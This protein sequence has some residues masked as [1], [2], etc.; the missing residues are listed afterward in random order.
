MIAAGGIL[1]LNI[2]L[3]YPDEPGLY[4]VDKE[5]VDFAK[6]QRKIAV[7]LLQLRTIYGKPQKTQTSYTQSPGQEIPKDML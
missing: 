1:G 4:D 6:R 7:V 3:A 2:V 5:Y